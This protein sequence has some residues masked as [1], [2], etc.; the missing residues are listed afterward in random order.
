MSDSKPLWSGRSENGLSKVSQKISESISFDKQLA[1]EDIALNRAYVTML[2][3]Q[4]IITKEQK[5]RIHSAIDQVEDEIIHNKMEYSF[6]LEDI[7]THIEDRIVQLIGQDGKR[8]HTGRSRNDQV[9]TDTHLYL[10]KQIEEQSK[11]LLRWLSVLLERAIQEEG[12][13]WAGY[14]HLQIAQPILLSHYLLS[15]FFKFERDFNLLSFAYDEADYLPLTSAALAGANYPLDVSCL[16]NLLGFSHTYANSIDAIS[17]RDYQ[18]SY[19]FFASR[20]FIHIS[21][22]CED[23]IIY[24]STEFQYVSFGGAVTTGSSIMPQ[25]RN[26]DIAEILRGKSGTVIGN[27]TSLLVNLKGLP[28]AYNRDLQEDKKYLFETC[29]EVN[30][31]LLG[32]I[33]LFQHITFHPNKV[34]GNLQRGFAMATDL[35][36]FLVSQCDMPFRE[37]HEMVAQ[38]VQ[39]CESNSCFLEDLTQQE[40]KKQLGRTVSI[41]EYFFQ[42]SNSVARKKSHNSTSPQSVKKQIEHAKSILEKFKSKNK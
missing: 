26:P 14:T 33:E 6:T 3:N 28:L 24:N 41:D 25:K 15:W 16:A 12:V 5:Q 21:R 39:Y 40:L 4:N 1:H 7:H 35:A 34:Q 17:N 2:A 22:L 38:L 37:A 32:L 9:A 10:K 27:F 20:F 18:L 23:L 13:I 29:K 36:D 30:M 11:L 31:G 8:I 42:L 19:H